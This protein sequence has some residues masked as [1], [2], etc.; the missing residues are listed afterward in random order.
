MSRADGIVSAGA[1][2]S[3]A[4]MLAILDRPA[5]DLEGGHH[6][7]QIGAR[8]RLQAV[9]AKDVEFLARFD[10][11]RAV[12]KA[13]VKPCHPQV[14]RLDHMTVGRIKLSLRLGGQILGTS[15]YGDCFWAY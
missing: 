2:L 13:L 12:A 6:A 9:H 15:K 1:H 11:G 3:L 5:L 4:I 10:M 8:E 7:A 14:G